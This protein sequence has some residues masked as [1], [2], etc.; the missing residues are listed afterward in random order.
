MN[1]NLLFSILSQG[2]K[3]KVLVLH[4]EV[5]KGVKFAH[6]T[7]KTF[8]GILQ[9]QNGKIKTFETEEEWLKFANGSEIK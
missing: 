6:D 5:C 4:F 1:S 2:T 9:V 7:C 8:F 3:M